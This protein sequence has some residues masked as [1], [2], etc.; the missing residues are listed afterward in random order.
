M[1]HFGRRPSVT[2]RFQYVGVVFNQARGEEHADL[3]VAY[4]AAAFSALA[5]NGGGNDVAR[6]QFVNETLAQ[7][8]T[9]LVPAERTA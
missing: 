8:L 7:P 5:Q 6:L 4:Y 2:K 3:S 9:S 1:P